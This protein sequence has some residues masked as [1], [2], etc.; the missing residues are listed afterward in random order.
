MCKISISKVVAEW[1]PQDFYL[2]PAKILKY[3]VLKVPVGYQ[4]FDQI[5][6]VIQE[7][8]IEKIKSLAAAIKFWQ[9]FERNKTKVVLR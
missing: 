1:L 2:N 6:E 3:K 5:C 8:S 7:V 9:E 4:I